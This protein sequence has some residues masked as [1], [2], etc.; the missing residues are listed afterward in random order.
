[1]ADAS[2]AQKPGDESGFLGSLSDRDD[3]A[4]S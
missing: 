1:M 3:A 2:M 4:S